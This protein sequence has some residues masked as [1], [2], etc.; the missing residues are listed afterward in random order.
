MYLLN[1]VLVRLHMRAIIVAYLMKAYT[2]QDTDPNGHGINVVMTDIG[3]K[4][5]ESNRWTKQR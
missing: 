5:M 4:Q 1:V 3:R 2:V